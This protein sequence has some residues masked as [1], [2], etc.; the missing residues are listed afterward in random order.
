LARLIF[1]ADTGKLPQYVAV[2]DAQRGYLLARIDAVKEV[3]L[4]DPQ[5]LAGY[6]QQIR[7]MTGEALLQAYMEELKSDAKIE[8]K[9]FVAAEK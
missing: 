2:A 5:K 8:M 4:I 9:D 7:Q 6:A 1:A 3:D